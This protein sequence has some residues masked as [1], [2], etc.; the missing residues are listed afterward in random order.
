MLTASAGMMS[1]PSVVTNCRH[2]GPELPGGPGPASCALAAAHHHGA[3]AVCAAEAD[4][5]WGLRADE[6]GR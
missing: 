2:A 4:K 3:A 6:A 5:V 1:S